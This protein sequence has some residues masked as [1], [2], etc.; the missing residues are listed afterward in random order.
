MRRHLEFGLKIFE[1]DFVNEIEWYLTFF[2]PPQGPRGRIQKCAVVRPIYVSNSHTKFSWI[3]S[4]G[5]GRDSVTDGQ[6]DGQADKVTNLLAPPQGAGHFF[7]IACPMHV[8]KSHTKF[9]WISSNVGR[10]DGGDCNIPIAFLI[11]R[12]DN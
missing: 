4:N 8:S 5:L 2:A 10:T 6:T 11:K 3:K 1:I 9:G 7:A 12:G